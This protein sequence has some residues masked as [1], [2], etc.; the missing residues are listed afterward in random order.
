M[1]PRVMG[2][3]DLERKLPELDATLTAMLEAARIP[4][5][6]IA[7]VCGSEVVHAKGYGYRSLEPRESMT[8]NTVY[9][10]ASTTKAFNATLVGMLVDEGKL[11]WDAP[12]QSYLPGFRLGGPI[13][14][15]EATI[16]DLLAMRT[17]LPR[18]D[19]LW[20]ENPLAR[21]DIVARLGHL[22]LS[23]GFREKFQYNNLTAT[24]VGHIAE[25]VTGRSWEDL[26]QERILSPLGMNAT[27]FDCPRSGDVALSYHESRSRQL[28][29]TQRLAG[30]VTAPSGG[31]MHSTVMD[32]TK[33]LGFNSNAG[34]VGGLK[35]IEP[36]T[37]AEIQSPQV[38]ARTDAACP[39]PNAAYGMGWFVDTYNG[40]SRIAHGGYIHD[41]NSS[42]MLFPEENVGLVSFI[43]FG[44]PR[45]ARLMNE[46]A[47]DV[48]WGT[49]PVQPASDKL[50]GY[51]RSLEENDKRLAALE[52]VANAPPSHQLAQYAGTY[53]HPGYGRLVI[54]L[55]GATLVFLRGALTLP[56]EHWHYDTWAFA[57]SDLFEIHDSHCFDHGSRVQ[58]DTDLDGAIAGL[59]TGLE[60]AVPAIRFQ[61]LKG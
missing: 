41:V 17:G 20:I 24:T 48:L 57:E 61:K 27:T 49:R 4:G 32:M 30:E 56:L 34:R 53:E 22:A 9:P 8:A 6:A 52:R 51:E 33:W 25:V 42:V 38:A 54:G 10:I 23:A 13:I 12:V 16:R 46:H 1:P 26:I 5:A 19:W 7:I 29:V 50:A 59:A 44:P 21:S 37:L 15:A 18:H 47:S 2:L 35:L 11:A 58:F 45:L 3:K 28:L 36:R 43:N 55:D 31:S 39:T 60:P 40:R 14:S